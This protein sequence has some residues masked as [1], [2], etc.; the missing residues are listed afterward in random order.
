MDDPWIPH[1]D[2]ET[3]L[4]KISWSKIRTREECKQKDHLRAMGY[5][6]PIKDVR[7]FF[8]G[9]VC[10]QLMRRW[11]SMES[12]P[13]N[14]MF[15][16]VDEV[17]DELENGQEEGVVRWRH[18]DDR[19]QV[20]NWCRECVYRL[21]HLLRQVAL[22]YEYQPAVRFKTKLGIPGPDGNQVKVLLVGEMD[23]LARE[24]APLSEIRI[25]PDPIE[26]ALTRPKYRIWDLK[27]TADPNYFRKTLA[28]LVFYDI[29]LACMF[30]QLA[31][32]VGLLQPMVEGQPAHWYTPSDQDRNE[33]YSRIIKVA[34]DI[35]R[36]DHSPK[37]GTEGCVWCEVR[38]ACVRYRTAPGT[39]QIALR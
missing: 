15:E 6:S 28:Q 3:G 7:V 23:L 13:R 1:V 12:P 11:L 25:D 14:W 27:A 20:R 2:A 34:H 19:Q 9:N 10:D 17:A 4:V 30:G 39:N 38:H 21:E 8:Q 35:W 16:H 29:A 31:D 32:V 22:P 24:P 26:I 5:S 18:R 33:M 37:D 36:G